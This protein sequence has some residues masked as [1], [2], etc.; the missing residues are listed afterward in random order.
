M[1]RIEFQGLVGLKAIDAQYEDACAWRRIQDARDARL[2]VDRRTRAG[3]MA[4]RRS[5]D[6]HGVSH[7]IMDCLAEDARRG[8][9]GG[10]SHSGRRRKKPAKTAVPHYL[11]AFGEV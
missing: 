6:Y 7:E 8:S 1:P 10:G 11:R 5:A 3:E 4:A 2:D 9:R